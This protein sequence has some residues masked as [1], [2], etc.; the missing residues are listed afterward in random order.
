MDAHFL[1]SSLVGDTLGPPGAGRS[2]ED[3]EH[4]LGEQQVEDVNALA[5][6]RQAGGGILVDNQPVASPYLIV[7]IGP[8]H[9]MQE[10]FEQTP[11][12][13]RLMLLAQSYGVG[14]SVQTRDKLTVSAGSV[15]DVN[16][17]KEIGPK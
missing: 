13:Q 12:M 8:P 16:F 6:H 7:A 9:A 1:N 17:A 15:R 11:A 2:A 14:I 3:G 4:A 10:V 5:G